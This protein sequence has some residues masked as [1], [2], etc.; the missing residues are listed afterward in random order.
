M[1]WFNKTVMNHNYMRNMRFLAQMYYT[2][3]ITNKCGI[4]MLERI[5]V[6]VGYNFS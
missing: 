2:T 6:K 5:D 1:S 4:T 3:H